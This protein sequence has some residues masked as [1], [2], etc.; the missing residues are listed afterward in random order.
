MSRRVLVQLE[1]SGIKP[2]VPRHCAEG[3]PDIRPRVIGVGSMSR[4]AR[5]NANS[6]LSVRSGWPGTIRIVQ[7]VE[8]H[9]RCDLVFL[10]G[11][12]VAD[13]Y[14]TVIAQFS[15]PNRAVR[16]QLPLTIDD[17]RDRFDITYRAPVHAVGRRPGPSGNIVD[18]HRFGGL[19]TE[20]VGSRNGDL[21]RAGNQ[22]RT[23]DFDVEIALIDKT[24]VTTD[25]H[26]Q[27]LARSTVQAPDE[28]GNALGIQ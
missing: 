2:V 1:L 21:V 11:A 4:P 9:L 14:Q 26:R 27:N 20:F 16:L 3:V 12:H 22:S 15:G 24:R 6:E 18:S 25:P 28:G 23:I 17:L 13:G 8:S 10:P 5:Y 7:V 19:F